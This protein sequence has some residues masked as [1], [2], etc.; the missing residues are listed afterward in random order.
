[1]EII[2]LDLLKPEPKIV[3]LNG[4]EINVSFIP[5]AITFQVD[6]TIREIQGL[7]AEKVQAGG[8]DTARAF[9]LGIKLCALYCSV[10]NPEMNEKWFM[11]NSS[12]AQVQVLVDC[13]RNAL[14]T[15][16]QQ[17]EDYSKNVEAVKAVP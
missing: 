6:E 8:D 5:C 10:K 15:G 13:I 7:D 17:V 9:K 2:D 16:Y 1:M 11:E 3:K 12:P 14:F 4:K